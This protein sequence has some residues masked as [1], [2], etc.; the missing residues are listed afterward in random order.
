MRSGNVIYHLT[1]VSVVYYNQHGLVICVHCELRVSR[2]TWEIL[3]QSW[4][5]WH[6]F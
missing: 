4:E 1:V 2:S 5:L 6:T 3:F